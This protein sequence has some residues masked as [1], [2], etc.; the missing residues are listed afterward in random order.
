MSSNALAA[1]ACAH[2][3]GGTADA[4]V[5]V[6]D[7]FTGAEGRF[8]Q[9]GSYHG[10]QVIADYAHHPAAVRATLEAAATIPHHHTWVVFQPL[11]FSRTQV[12]FDEFVAALKDCEWVI[13][14]EI[15]SDRET[16]RDYVSSRQLADRINELGGHAQFARD[17]NEIRAEL[18]KRVHPGDLILVLGR[19]NPGTGDQLTGRVHHP[20]EWLGS[21]HRSAPGCSC[22]STF[23]GVWP[24]AMAGHWDIF[25][26][27]RFES[28]PSIFSFSA[29]LAMASSSSRA[30]RRISRTSA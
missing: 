20:A 27:Q 8:T 19:R 3:C 30:P 22:S 7:R 24:V 13:F 1:I 10:A 29:G 21:R 14:A 5:R 26:N 11:T 4:A 9:T 6:L 28:L 16:V 12:L 2:L 15:F 18:D 23:V 17:F 25:P